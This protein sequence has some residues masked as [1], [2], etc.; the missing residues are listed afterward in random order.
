[1]SAEVIPLDSYRQEKSCRYCRPGF[2]CGPHRLVDLAARVEDVRAD[3]EQFRA[4]DWAT[5][6]RL[7]AD[8]LDVL[9]GIVAETL[10]DE[11]GAK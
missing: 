4:C 5:F 9:D 10:P 2:V 7:T 6:K 8:V 11:R 3:V 1:M